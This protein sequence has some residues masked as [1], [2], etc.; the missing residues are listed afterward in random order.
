[1]ILAHKYKTLWYGV[2]KFNTVLLL[3]FRAFSCCQLMDG[4]T[5][6]QLNSRLLIY[7]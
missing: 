2:V 5:V 6:K 4:L 7:N 3:M 1:M